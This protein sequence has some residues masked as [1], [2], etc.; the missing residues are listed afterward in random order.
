MPGDEWQ[1]FA[2]LRLLHGLQ[3]GMPG[4]KLLF[5]GGEF[6]QRE[7][8]D[9][10]RS[11]SWHVLEH[12][13][14][15]GVAAWVSHLNALHRSVPALHELDC[16]PGGFRWLVADDEAQCVFVWLRFAYDAHDPVIV[17][18]NATPVPRPGYRV[19]VPFGGA[20]DV[21]ANS[22]ASEFGGSGY[23]LAPVHASETNGMHGEAS[24]IVLDLPPL[25]LVILRR[26]PDWNAG[27]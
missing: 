25:A 19:G 5:M 14:H 12:P 2:N 22:D 6:G 13:S 18:A 7:E 20:W 4:K 26:R 17:V 16:E 1:A 3:S 24:S 27:S 15:A 10:D 8:W 9:H 11:L 21:I 23:G